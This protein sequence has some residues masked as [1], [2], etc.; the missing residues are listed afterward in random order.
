MEASGAWS[1]H[2]TGR[3]IT[4]ELMLR[5]FRMDMA[6]SFGIPTFAFSDCQ[7]QRKHCQKLPLIKKDLEGSQEPARSDQNNA[8]KGA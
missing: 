8:L 3:T 5:I 6:I 7:Y 4:A 2:K 1:F